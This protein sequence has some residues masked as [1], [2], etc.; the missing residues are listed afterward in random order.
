VRNTQLMHAA[1]ASH[2]SRYQKTLNASPGT[3]VALLNARVTETG[4]DDCP[5]TTTQADEIPDDLRHFLCFSAARR[6]NGQKSV[7]VVLE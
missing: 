1:L 2:V 6:A 5:T 4:G 7:A 3:A